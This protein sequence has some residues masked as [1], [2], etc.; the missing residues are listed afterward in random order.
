MGTMGTLCFHG[1]QGWTL[2]IAGGTWA[3]PVGSLRLDGRGIARTS[4]PGWLPAEEGCAA[5]SILQAPSGASGGGCSTG[6]KGVSWVSLSVTFRRVLKKGAKE[7]PTA[8]GGHLFGGARLNVNVG[9]SPLCS[10][11]RPSRFTLRFPVLT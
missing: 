1:F 9:P 10:P 5:G 2:G 7:K 6:W 4:V 11:A 3:K 8:F